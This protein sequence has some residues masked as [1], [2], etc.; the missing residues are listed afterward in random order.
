MLAL[1]VQVRYLYARLIR[2]LLYIWEF[3]VSLLSENSR[4]LS[5]YCR[6]IRTDL[7]TADYPQNE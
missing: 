4:I 2:H 6:Q 5:V 3:P 1:G 7:V